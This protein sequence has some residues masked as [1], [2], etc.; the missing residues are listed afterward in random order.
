MLCLSGLLNSLFYIVYV[1]NKKGT[2]L[3][4][5]KFALRIPETGKPEVWDQQD[6][7]SNFDVL[8]AS[9]PGIDEILS[10]ILNIGG[11]D[12]Q[13]L[14]KYKKSG[15]QDTTLN[16]D[17]ETFEIVDG[18][19]ML[20]FDPADYFKLF[21]HQLYDYSIQQ[22][23][24]FAGSSYGRQTEWTDSYTAEEDWKEGYVLQS[25]N[26]DNL[27]KLDKIIG[28]VASPLLQQKDELMKDYRNNYYS[29]CSEVLNAHREFIEKMT[30]E[31]QY[32]TDDAYTV[33]IEK[34]INDE[35]CDVL[36]PLGIESKVCFRKYY[37]SVDN[38]LSLYEKYGSPQKSIR[39]V[40][41]AAIDSEISVT[42]IFENFYEYKDDDTVSI[43]NCSHIFHKD[44]IQNWLCNE[45]VTC[46]VCRKDTREELS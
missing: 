27:E 18:N 4:N 22:L 31:Y 9:M 40:I 35:Y 19:V 15:K 25:L 11:T 26:D 28:V 37:T 32:A 33:G 7:R 2:N 8:Y 34:G 21:K 1:I 5:S 14:I 43:L 24:S 45:R 36:Q 13:T 46:P 29:K 16:I 44:C 41:T 12:Y 39:A 3:R 23:E 6:S 20:F 30:D 17:D 10:N 38:M 42:D